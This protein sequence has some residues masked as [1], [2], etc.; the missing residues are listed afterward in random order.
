M[1]AFFGKADDDGCAELRGIL[2]PCPIHG[3]EQF[4]LLDQPTKVATLSKIF[5]MAS[6]AS[7]FCPRC[8]PKE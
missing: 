3:F 6:G 2:S 8:I 5:R 7:G 4:F 1:G